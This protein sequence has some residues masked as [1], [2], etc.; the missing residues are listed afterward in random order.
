MAINAS[1]TMVEIA[2]TK[3]AF[4]AEVRSSLAS[5]CAAFALAAADLAPDSAMSARTL[6]PAAADSA[7]LRIAASFI[8]TPA[9]TSRSTSA[10]AWRIRARSASS[11]AFR[12]LSNEPILASSN[13][14]LT[15]I[16]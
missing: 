14:Y 13:Y 1:A 11:A 4:P 7:A 12:S 3:L 5:A 2:A 16:T 10:F 8:A 15:M 6:S 9:T